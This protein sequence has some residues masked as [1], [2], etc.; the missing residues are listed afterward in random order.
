MNFIWSFLAGLAVWFITPFIATLQGDTRL[1]ASAGGAALVLGILFAVGKVSY[2]RGLEAA[3][4][5]EAANSE[6][7]QS[8]SAQPGVQVG[9]G[10][11]AK[12]N[13][14][15]RVGKVRSNGD[16]GV[17]VGKDIDAGQSASVHVDHVEKK[18]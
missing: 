18:P 13:V 10:I 7:E 1:A 16:G 4:A 14:T 5:E 3:K 2:R 15:V 9:V 17:D 12:K 6:V 8:Q 11:K